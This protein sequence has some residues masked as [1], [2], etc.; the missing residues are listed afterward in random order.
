MS[1]TVLV[2]GASGFIGSRLCR[3]L[4]AAGHD[5]RAMTRRPD[6]YTG[7]GKPVRGDVQDPES[8]AAALAGTDAAYYLVHSL[9]SDDFERKDAAAA[10]NFAQAAADAGIE[11]IVY[12]GGLGADGAKLS[13]H[14][15]SRREVEQLLSSTSVPVT[16]L[17]AAVVVGHGGI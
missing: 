7:A 8:L 11:R 12:L 10:R 9:E 3:A 14:L 17:R 16:A 6:H 1:R 5:V 4:V 15:R 2:T 13:P